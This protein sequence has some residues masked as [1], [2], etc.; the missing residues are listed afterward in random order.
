MSAICPLIGVKRDTSVF[1]MSLDLLQGSQ[2]SVNSSTLPPSQVSSSSHPPTHF[3]THLSLSPPTH[4]LSIHSSACELSV[5]RRLTSLV[6]TLT[7]RSLDYT[8][9]NFTRSTQKKENHLLGRLTYSTDQHGE[10]HVMRSS[11]QFQVLQQEF[12]TTEQVMKTVLLLYY[13][14]VYIS[15]SPKLMG[16]FD[17]HT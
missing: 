14:D 2:A 17:Y 13:K 12:H 10:Q 16:Y 9:G 5:S 8:E 11:A 15:V 3:Y 6:N 7:P 1:V 4:T